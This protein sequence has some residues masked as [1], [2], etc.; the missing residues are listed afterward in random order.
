MNKGNYNIGHELEILVREA[1]VNKIDDKGGSIDRVCEMGRRFDALVQSLIKVDDNRFKSELQ[2][3]LENAGAGWREPEERILER[4][5]KTAF[6]VIA[7]RH[8]RT[9][10]AI[11]ARARKL[12][13]Y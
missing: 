2:R 9:Y 3:E 11:W 7:D 6:Q 1:L 4:E 10:N 12:L 5:L 8:G 13:K